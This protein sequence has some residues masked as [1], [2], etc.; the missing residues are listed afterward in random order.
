MTGTETTALLDTVTSGAKGLAP[1]SGGGTANFLR[2]DGTW[3]TPS[4]GG[5]GGTM[6]FALPSAQ[7]MYPQH[8][9]TGATNTQAAATAQRF[10][11]TPMFIARDCT[12]TDAL[13]RVQ[14]LESGATMCLG[15]YGSDDE[16]VP[17]TLIADFGT[18]S[19][20]TTGDKTITGLSQALSQ[21]WVFL[22]TWCSNHSTVRY[23]KFSVASLGVW[24]PFGH[25]TSQRTNWGRALGGTIDYS[26]GLPS[27]PPTTAVVE[28]V[29]EANP[30]A[31]WIKVT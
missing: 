8:M 1:A 6:P 22:A 10:H 30:P 23:A 12:V 4:G 5:G 18:V 3:A 16:L 26:A 29:T 7:W 14:T 17:T 24:S 2:A 9:G 13:A 15:I 25:H 28:H 19:A 21:G 27:T 20:T 11:L 31:M